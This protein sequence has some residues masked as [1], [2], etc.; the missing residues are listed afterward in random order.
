M[1]SDDNGPA[2]QR[3]PLTEKVRAEAH[4]HFDE[5]LTRL[6]AIQDA[7]TANQLLA[8]TL[9][10]A[11]SLGEAIMANPRVTAMNSSLVTQAVA[12][13]GEHLLIAAH[14]DDEAKLDLADRVYAGMVGLIRDTIGT[15]AAETRAERGPVAPARSAIPR[16]QE[17]DTLDSLD[18]QIIGSINS[19]GGEG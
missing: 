14:F 7:K 13:A 15:A 1:D 19:V 17:L 4:R 11:S 3:S 5:F 9:L 18:N 12:C 10:A 8:T 16:G 6:D 2:T